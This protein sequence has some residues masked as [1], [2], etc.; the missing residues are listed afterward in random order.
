MMKLK[1]AYGFHFMPF[2]ALVI[3]VKRRGRQHYSTIRLSD[4]KLE[5]IDKDVGK[6]N[7][8][9]RMTLDSLYY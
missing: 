2:R 1:I 9:P 6:W 4:V 7:G 3:V 5:D 8:T